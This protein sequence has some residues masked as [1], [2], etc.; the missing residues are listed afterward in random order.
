MCHKETWEMLKSR[1]FLKLIYNGVMMRFLKFFMTLCVLFSAAQYANAEDYKILVLPDN[2]QF[3]STNYYVYPDTSVMFA[4][5]VINEIKKDGRVQTVSMT[6]IRDALRKNVHLRMLTKSALKE[7]KYN[8]NIP[9]V[10]FREIA[11][12]F[13]TNKILIITS[14]TDVQNYVLRRTIWDFL[15]IPGATVVDPA[16]KLS[17]Y[18]ALVDVDKEQVLWQNT[19][20]KM[21][22]TMENRMIAQSFAPATEQ[23]EKIKFY[24]QYLLSPEIARISATRILPPPIILP[25]GGN[26]VEISNSKDKNE[27]IILPPDDIELKNKMPMPIRTSPQKYGAVVNDL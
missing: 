26:V 18:I 3:E 13:S 12:C 15:N 10:D 17:T 19:Y 5:D 11:R 27:K 23:L 24:S 14:Q 9:F 25:Q 6:E 16:Y 1:Q 2:I 7:F 20:Y 21:I 8:Y 4:S 22:S